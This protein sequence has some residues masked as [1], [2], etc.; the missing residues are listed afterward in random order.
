MA[1]AAGPRLLPRSS[2][3]PDHPCLASIVPMPAVPWSAYLAQPPRNGLLRKNLG[4]QSLDSPRN[5]RSA[6]IGVSGQAQ[7][8]LSYDITLDLA[9]AASYGKTAGGEET[10]SPTTRTPLKRSSMCAT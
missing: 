1:I 10:L 6:D 4:R 3:R 7:E 8:T 9:G 5:L 2:T